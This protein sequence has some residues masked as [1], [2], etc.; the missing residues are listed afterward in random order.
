MYQARLLI[1]GKVQGVFYRA[2][3]QEIA[4]RLGL[5]GWVKNLSDGNVEALAQG[6]KEKIENL[7]AWCKKGPP[8]AVV[9]NL[10]VNWE[11]VVK[12]ITSF[13]IVN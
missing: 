6:E 7:I 11:T 12:Q 3:C 2:S 4:Q 1:T 10:D 13:N 8:G 5:N 9:S